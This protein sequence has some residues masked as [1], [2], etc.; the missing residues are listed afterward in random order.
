[1]VSAVGRMFPDFFV[2]LSFLL[3]HLLPLCSSGIPGQTVGQPWPLPQSYLPGSNVQSLSS[4]TFRFRVVGKD[5]DILRAAIVRYYKLIFRTPLITAPASDDHVLRFKPKDGS[6]DWELEQDNEADGGLEGIDVEVG[7]TCSGL[8]Y[9][10]LD[11]DESCR[12]KNK[13]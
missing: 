13:K 1:M 3:L 2:A 4:D 12:F 7:Q 6:R 9:P 10:S 8:V 5:C 11:M